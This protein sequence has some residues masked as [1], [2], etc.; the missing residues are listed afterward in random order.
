MDSL[1]SHAGDERR[2][3]EVLDERARALTEAGEAWKK[4]A[5]PE[6]ERRILEAEREWGTAF[7]DWVSTAK[8]LGQ[9]QNRRRSEEP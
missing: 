5:T 3:R 9:L 6:N 8:S 7:A 4:D 2:R 1:S